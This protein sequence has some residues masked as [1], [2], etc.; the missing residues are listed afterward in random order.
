MDYSKKSV[1]YMEFSEDDI[2]SSSDEM[3]FDEALSLL[4]VW[5]GAQEIVRFMSFTEKLNFSLHTNVSRVDGRTLYL[6]ALDEQDRL[7]E[8]VVDLSDCR[9]H[10]WSGERKYR[11]RTAELYS[12]VLTMT[13]PNGTYMHVAR[14]RSS[15]TALSGAPECLTRTLSNP[16]GLLN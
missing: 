10:L 8:A 5:A 6:S 4:A 14:C 7:G 15:E 13:R 1:Q 3:A 12:A 16:G 11:P 2:R 9:F